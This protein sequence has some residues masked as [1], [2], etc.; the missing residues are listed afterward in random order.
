MWI[1]ELNR[2]NVPQIFGDLITLLGNSDPPILDIPSVG[3]VDDVLRLEEKGLYG[4]EF[5]VVATLNQS[6]KSVTPL[7]AAIRRRFGFFLNQPSN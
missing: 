6:S 5:Y 3:L 7:D 2:G 1:D 4:L